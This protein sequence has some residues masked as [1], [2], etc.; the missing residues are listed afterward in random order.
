MLTALIMSRWLH[1]RLSALQML[2]VAVG[3][4]GVAL[5][6]G[7]RGR[8][9]GD[10]AAEPVLAVAWALACVTGGT[11]Y[12]RQFC[13]DGRPAARRSASTSRSRRSLM[14]PLGA[15]LRGLRHRLETR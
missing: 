13:A 12:Q 14:L 3:L 1:E 5:V 11:L 8:R 9:R 2:G 7:H 6:V 15:R 10:R 4:G